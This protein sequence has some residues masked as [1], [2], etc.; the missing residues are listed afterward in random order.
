MPI[1]LMNTP[2]SDN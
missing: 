1:E 2:L